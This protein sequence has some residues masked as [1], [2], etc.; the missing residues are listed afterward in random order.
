MDRL[1]PVSW[2]YPAG[3]Y[4]QTATGYAVFGGVIWV[5]PPPDPRLTN[6]FYPYAVPGLPPAHRVWGWLEGIDGG[7]WEDA[8]IMPN[9]GDP[10]FSSM[11]LWYRRVVLRRWDRR[12]D[13]PAT[14]GLYPP[15]GP[16]PLT[17]IT[18]SSTSSDPPLDQPAESHPTETEDSAE[19][20]LANNSEYSSVYGFVDSSED[21]SED[22][23]GDGSVHSSDDSPEIARGYMARHFDFQD[24]SDPP[25]PIRGNF[26]PVS[27]ATSS[28]S[29][30]P[31][32]QG[33]SLSPIQETVTESE[34]DN[35]K[36]L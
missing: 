9:G 23:S 11:I 36:N 13:D 20:N 14:F 5:P 34:E 29:P 6:P 10:G 26:I 2:V 4:S 21:D 17:V 8:S 7:V 27:G 3:Y 19:N 32:Q 24:F 30:S 22:D 31:I 15:L 12:G 33:D 16:R 25:S 18:L 28:P 1:P 35:L